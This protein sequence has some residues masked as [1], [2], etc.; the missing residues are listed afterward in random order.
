MSFLSISLVLLIY[1][2]IGLKSLSTHTLDV[3]NDGIKCIKISCFGLTLTIPPASF[4]PKRRAWGWKDG[5]SVWR[6]SA[7]THGGIGC[8][9]KAP[10]ISRTRVCC[11]RCCCSRTTA[12]GWCLVIAR[13]WVSSP[14]LRRK[15]DDCGTWL[16]ATSCGRWNVFMEVSQIRRVYPARRRS[17]C[18]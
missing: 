12:T 6:L 17:R 9:W 18:F 11:S 4:T 10:Q 14:Y 8:W 7:W 16:V 13:S 15:L 3:A 5:V 2:M 1:N